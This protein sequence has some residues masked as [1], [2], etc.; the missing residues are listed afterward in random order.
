MAYL[1]SKTASQGFEFDAEDLKYH[2]YPSQT[3][4]KGLFSFKNIG[5]VA[6][7]FIFFFLIVWLVPLSVRSQLVGLNDE[8]S[9]L[10]EERL[11]YESRWRNFQHDEAEVWKEKQ[12]QENIKKEHEHELE[13][14]R[15]EIGK[16]QREKTA[17][18]EEIGKKII[19]KQAIDQEVKNGE[20]LKELDANLK[21]REQQL[22]LR[23][24]SL[25]GKENQIQQNRD[26]ISKEVQQ[27][28]TEKQQ[29]TQVGYTLLESHK[30]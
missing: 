3:N 12:R 9:R 22:L 10:A 7:G 11:T 5:L 28:Q 24:N 13:L 4:L 27:L 16:R 30:D 14:L 18:D 17:L 19:Q 23:E 25:L 8:W 2:Q 6:L 20:K 29:L 1:R 15:N 21:F 26:A